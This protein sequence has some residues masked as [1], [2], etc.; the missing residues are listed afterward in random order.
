MLNA[1]HAEVIRGGVSLNLE[2]DQLV[3]D[4]IVVFRAGNQICADAVVEAG[5]VQVNESLLTGESDEITKKRGDRLMS[6]SFVVS[7]SCHARLDKVG[8]DSYISQL[9]LE[10]KAMQR[11]GTVGDDPFPGQAGKNGR[12]RT[13]PDR[14]HFVCAELFL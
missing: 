11:G 6:G 9:T 2:A 8:A 10:A 5:E 13:D 4:D 7:G 3:V 14:N 12:N 1:P